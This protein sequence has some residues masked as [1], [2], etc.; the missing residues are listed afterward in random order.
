MVRTVEKLKVIL[1]WPG[2]VKEERERLTRVI[3]KVNKIISK[4]NNLEFEL[5]TWDTDSYL[6]LHINGPQGKIDE[7]LEFQDADIV[8]GIFWT[9]FGTPIPGS[10]SGTEHELKKAIALWQRDSKPSVKIFFSQ[11]PKNPYEIDFEQ[12]KKILDFRREFQKRG[13]Y[14][15]YNSYEDFE[16]IAS[17]NL[18]Q[19]AQKYQNETKTNKVIDP[20]SEKRSKEENTEDSTKPLKSTHVSN[21]FNSSFWICQVCHDKFTSYNDYVIHFEENHR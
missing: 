14:A 9:K 4:G 5:F 7:D 15:S 13:I 6:G 21:I 19:F 3:N 12:F 10:N 17:N 18:H 1:A 8:F 2:D 11:I 20:I 16:E